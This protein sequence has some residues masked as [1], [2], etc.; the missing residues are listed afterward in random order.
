MRKSNERRSLSRVR[1]LALP[2]VL[3]SLSACVQTTRPA[4]EPDVAKVNPSVASMYSAIDDGG[5]LVPAVDAA[6]IESKNVRQ[7][8][9]YQTKEPPGTIVVDPYARFL[10]LVM[11]NGKAMRYGVGV[12]KAGLEFVGEAD[13][14][15]KA[16]WPGWTPTQDM[17]K[18][19]PERY[20]PL[21]KGLPGGLKNPLG[22]RAL[23]LYKGGQDTLYRIHGTNEPWSIGKSVSS[24]CIRMLNQDIIDLHRRV[25]KGSRVVVLGPEQSGKGE[26]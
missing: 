12:A 16:Q 1:R 26:I 2:L 25:P 13:I 21:A 6:K 15:R 8:V 5:N 11:E 24:G 17:I 3:L 4:A 18:R 7:V 14:A 22:A 10:Y 20:E 9:E 19:D 23:Y